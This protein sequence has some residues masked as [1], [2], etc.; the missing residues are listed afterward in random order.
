MLRWLLRLYWSGQC[1]G[2][3]SVY[4]STKV[5]IKPGY[6]PPQSTGDIPPAGPEPLDTGG[7][8]MAD[9]MYNS[10]LTIYIYHVFI[11]IDSYNYYYTRAALKKN[12][13]RLNIWQELDKIISLVQPRLVS[14]REACR[15][16]SDGQTLQ[17]L[18]VLSKCTCTW[19]FAELQSYQP[20]ALHWT[21]RSTS[22]AAS[23][24]H[25]SRNNFKS[26]RHGFF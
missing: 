3:L 22:S 11:Y 7:D 25:I 12:K 9:A 8:S 23:F 26:S 10:L 16:D 24:H 15:V 21:D 2:C 14:C 18:L 4:T 5:H 17:P 20:L 6:G 19:D 13:I 1:W